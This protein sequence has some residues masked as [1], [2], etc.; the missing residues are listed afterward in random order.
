M[1]ERDVEKGGPEEILS[2]SQA[3]SETAS[4]NG[5]TVHDIEKRPGSSTTNE[6]SDDRSKSRDVRP[7]LSRTSTTAPAPAV[8]IPRSQRRG[9][10]AQFCL[11]PEVDEPTYQSR[12]SKWLITFIVAIAAAAAPSGSGILLRE[13]IKSL[14]TGCSNVVR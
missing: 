2:Q 11:L 6:Q 8:P 4:E 1:T 3:S 12:R 10:L 7:T 5:S 14:L 9:L 13:S